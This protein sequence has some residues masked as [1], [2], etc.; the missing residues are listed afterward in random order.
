M[1]T[2]HQQKRALAIHDI[3]CIG[4]CSLTVALPILSVAGIETAIIPTSILSTHTGGFSGFTFRD[5]TEDILPIVNHWQTL[6]LNFDSIYTGYLGSIKQLDIVTTLF[7]QLKGDKTLLFIDPVMGDNGHLYTHFSC[8]FPQQMARFCQH[9]DIITP[10]I[11]EALLMLNE[12]YREGP[13]QQDY[14]ESILKRLAAL[15]PK[16][17]VL[18][19]VYLID[20]ASEIGVAAYD[21]KV[22]RV[23]YQFATKIR[24]TYHGTGDIFASS[25]LAALLNDQ[26]LTKALSIAIEFTVNSIKRTKEA[27]SDIRYG[28]NFEAGLSTL[29]RLLSSPY[30]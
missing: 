2:T 16:L 25:L 20:S 13:Y 17:V 28:V 8:D 10:N 22:E 4:R 18:T 21:Q 11:T 7:Q 24:G 29:G 26:P 5:L 12:P 3:S 15:G 6:S 19:G 27:G 30:D 23:I 1:E 9:A 14:I